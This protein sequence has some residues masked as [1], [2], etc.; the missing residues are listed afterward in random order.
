MSKTFKILIIIIA[1]MFGAFFMTCELFDSHFAKLTIDWFA[2]LAGVFLIIEG[3]YRIFSTKDQFF[4][5]QF[6]RLI[7]VSIGTCVFTI[8]LLQFMRF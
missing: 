4:P 3:L 2:F 7:R 1:L 5:L 6:S 8:H